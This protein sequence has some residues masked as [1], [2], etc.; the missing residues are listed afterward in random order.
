MAFDQNIEL[1]LPGMG[2][3]TLISCRPMQR[4]AA[5]GHQRTVVIP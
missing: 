3:I 4:R 1:A 5:H 2:W